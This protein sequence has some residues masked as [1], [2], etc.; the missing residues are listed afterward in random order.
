MGARQD[1]DDR[2][3]QWGREVC[4][5][6]AIRSWREPFQ[7]IVPAIGWRRWSHRFRSRVVRG[8][9]RGQRQRGGGRHEIQNALAI[10]PTGGSGELRLRFPVRVQCESIVGM[11]VSYGHAVQ[12]NVVVAVRAL[13]EV[14][15]VQGAEDGQ[16]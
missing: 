11:T 1:S 10:R 16:S 12:V 8:V 2:R 7:R 9:E 4:P 5:P 15:I 3:R 14:V 6:Q 13:G